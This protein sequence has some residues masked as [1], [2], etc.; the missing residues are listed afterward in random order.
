MNRKQVGVAALCLAAL[1]VPAQ[2]A[3]DTQERWAALEELYTQWLIDQ[4]PEV[5][6]QKVLEDP[7]A[8]I[9]ALILTQTHLQGELTCQRRKDLLKSGAC[10][11]DKPDERRPGFGFIDELLSR[12]GSVA[13]AQR[14]DCPVD[15]GSMC[16]SQF[17]ETVSSC[18]AILNNRCVFGHEGLCRRL[19]PRA[20]QTCMSVAGCQMDC[21]TSHC[22]GTEC[23]SWV[24]AGEPSDGPKCVDCLTR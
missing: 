8:T 3:T 21:C 7:H 18:Q 10:T 11:D 12:L 6:A 22:S 20:F 9:F 23:A 2:D 4:A 14:L 15:Y 24:A 5:D 1:A 19:R 16:Q 13:Y 17:N